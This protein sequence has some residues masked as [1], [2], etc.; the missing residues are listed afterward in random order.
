MYTLIIN[1]LCHILVEFFFPILWVTNSN[2]QT[3]ILSFRVVKLSVKLGR[4]VSS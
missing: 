4:G 3:R 2:A 1:H